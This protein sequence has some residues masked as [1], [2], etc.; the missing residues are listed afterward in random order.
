MNAEC[1][2][3]MR[4][5]NLNLWDDRIWI[6]ETTEFESMRRQNLNLWDDRIFT[7][8]INKL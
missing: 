8:Q 5:Q 6:Y 3:F 4:R 1:N 7:T 2:E